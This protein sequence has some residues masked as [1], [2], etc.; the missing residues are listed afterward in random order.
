MFI[1]ISWQTYLITLLG[2][3]AIYY[4]GILL[5][6]YRADFISLF[7][8]K[9]NPQDSTEDFQTDSIMGEV[10]QDERYSSVSSQELQ[11]HHETEIE[12]S[13]NHLIPTPHED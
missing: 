6:Y 9:E 12:Q 4:L 10:K 5:L 11:F 1:S 13:E 2:I 7:I 3:V 8:G